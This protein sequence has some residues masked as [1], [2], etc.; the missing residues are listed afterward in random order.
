MKREKHHV[1]PIS[2]FWPDHDSNKELMESKEHSNLHKI[3]NI[4]SSMVRGLRC[5]VNDIL[6][7]TP[8]RLKHVHA[9]QKKYFN[10]IDRLSNK[11]VYMHAWSFTK[12]IRRREWQ[13]AD[14]YDALGE[15]WLVID[16]GWKQ[17]P[18]RKWKRPELIQESKEKMQ[19]LFALEQLRARKNIEY[20]Q[21]MYQVRNTWCKSVRNVLQ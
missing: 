13:L 7:R 15:E 2:L 12:Q 18:S 16:E 10:N 21:K 14:L 11:D 19:M 8:E 9:M 4:S 5:K 17:R 3:L 20:V 6:L 1:R